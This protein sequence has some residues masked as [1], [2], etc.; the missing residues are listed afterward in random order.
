MIRVALFVI[1]FLAYITGNAQTTESTVA[2]HFQKGDADIAIFPEN[3]ADMLPGAKR[4]TPAKAEVEKAEL[5][6]VKQLAELN[7]DR[8]NQYDTPIIH[9]KLNRYK[10]QYFGYYD[11]KGKKILL[12]NCFWEK[13]KEVIDSW[14]NERIRVLD[15]GSYYWNV[16]YNIEEDRLFDL[17]VNGE[18]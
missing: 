17:S 16:K 10:R 7:S 3:S 14:L 6:L 15:G 12:I 11:S 9:K 18:A 4:F 8:Q 2:E 1:S 5:A 13:D